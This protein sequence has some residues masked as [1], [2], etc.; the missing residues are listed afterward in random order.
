ME[1]IESF[2]PF[3]LNAITAMKQSFLKFAPWL[4]LIISIV[5][6]V[7][8]GEKHPH[9]VPPP[10]PMPAVS[11]TNA[12]EL[13]VANCGQ[14]SSDDS[15]EYDSPRPPIPTRII[16]YRRF[17][18]RFIF[19]PGKPTTLGDPPP[20]RWDLIGIADMKASDPSKA[21]VVHIPE[22][23]RRMPCWH[24]NAEQSDDTDPAIESFYANAGRIR[25]GETV[26]LCYGV[27]HAKTVTLEPQ[28]N[29]VWPSH[30]HC[31]DVKPAKSTIYTLTARGA[32]GKTV[33][34]TIAIQVQ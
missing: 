28:D 26:Q 8:F 9:A 1:R 24:R 4:S 23:D 19:I 30:S 14:P 31:A 29:P 10:A 11:A 25:S 33:S 17:G 18:L 27:A 34:Q 7:I 32:S 15:R 2:G 6:Y 20:Y 5:L 16:E 22:A 12:A 13:L 21:R 3:F